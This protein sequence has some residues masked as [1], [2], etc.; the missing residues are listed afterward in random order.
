MKEQLITTILENQVYIYVM[1]MC[2]Y[3]WREREREGTVPPRM[4]A[5]TSLTARLVRES[6]Q[7]KK[8]N[9]KRAQSLPRLEGE[10]GE[11]G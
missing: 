6:S 8:R 10:E 3:I 9:G 1:Y 7:E 2:A 4:K 5:K 11:R